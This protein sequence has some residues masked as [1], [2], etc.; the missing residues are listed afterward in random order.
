VT[1][2]DLDIY[3]A[4]RVRVPYQETLGNA[5][6]EAYMANVAAEKVLAMFE[7]K[8]AKHYK[9]WWNPKESA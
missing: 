2:I 5:L 4:T 8:M 1:I 6:H 3:R 9:P 7:P